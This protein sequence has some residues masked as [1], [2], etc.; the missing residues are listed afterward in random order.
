L[1]ET[2]GDD[3]LASIMF[4]SGSSGRPKGAMMT[5]KNIIANTNS[6][7]SYLKLSEKDIIEV[8]LPFYYCYGL[9]LL[10]THT[11][12]GGKVV[13]NNKFIFPETVIKDIK[14]YNCTGF[15][16]VPSHY[17]ILIK[18]TNFLNEELP[19]LK[20]VTQAGGKMD[21][22]TILKIF[23]SM[24]N[25]KLYIMYGQTEATARLSY[26]PPE[27]LPEKLGSIGKGIPGVE[28]KILDDSSKVCE[29][30]KIG[31]LVALGENVMKGYYKDYKETEKKIKNGFLYTGDLAMMDKDG[32]IYIKGRAD[33]LIKVGG[34]RISLDEITEEIKKIDGV[35]NC[36]AASVEDRIFGASIVCLVV[37]N[38]KMTEDELLVSAKKKLANYKV[39]S[40]FIIVNQ[41]PLTLSGKIAKKEIE[42]IIKNECRY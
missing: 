42:E 33:N 39:P 34:F 25:I 27:N 38:K 35:S 10:H 5:H 17:E 30:E 29:S 23:N 37:L 31:E 2:V 20:Y 24:K 7:I 19:S 12:V 13:L 11:K 26:L 9:S 14:K 40:K 8:V 4:T 32:F 36:Y 3:D 21:N 1:N 15:A 22:E 18:N 41:I 28:L 6:I 16:G